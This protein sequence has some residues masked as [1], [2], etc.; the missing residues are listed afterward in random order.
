MKEGIKASVMSPGKARLYSTIFFASLHMVP[1]L[2]KTVSKVRMLVNE[3]INGPTNTLEDIRTPLPSSTDLAAMEE[4]QQDAEQ[5]R[6]KEMA[7]TMWD[8]IEIGLTLFQAIA[9]SRLLSAAIHLQLDEVTMVNVMSTLKPNV[10]TEVVADQTAIYF[11]ARAHHRL[12]LDFSRKW[13]YTSFA[14][15]GLHLAS[16]IAQII[17]TTKFSSKRPRQGELVDTQPKNTNLTFS[18]FLRSAVIYNV[19][20]IAANSLW[21]SIYVTSPTFQP[22]GLTSFTMKVLNEI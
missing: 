18:H 7:W 13:I 6:L 8:T 20:S 21:Y 10:A 15:D 12:L 14:L 9:D 19:I 1:P 16:N 3:W 4:E 2:V 17:Y 22:K 5:K 11:R